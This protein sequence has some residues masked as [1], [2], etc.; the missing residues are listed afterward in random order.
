MI[1][2]ERRNI[3]Y[4]KMKVALYL[5]VSTEDQAKEGYSLEVQREYL[6]SFAKR[7]G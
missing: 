4:K 2:D 6:E 7:I 1:N 3:E 5:R